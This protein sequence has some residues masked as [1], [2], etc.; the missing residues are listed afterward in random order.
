MVDG[1]LL[2]NPPFQGGVCG[3]L[4]P[5]KEV[6]RSSKPRICEG[7]RGDAAREVTASISSRVA[8]DSAVRSFWDEEGGST[9]VESGGEGEE[10]AV[11][12]NGGDSEGRSGMVEASTCHNE[13]QKDVSADPNDHLTKADAA[14]EDAPN[15]TSDEEAQEEDPALALPDALAVGAY[16]T[17]A[18][19]T[20]P[21]I[22]KHG[23]FAKIVAIHRNDFIDHTSRADAHACRARAKIGDGYGDHDDSVDV[24]YVLGGREKRVAARYVEVSGDLEVAPP[25]R[26]TLGRCAR[27]HCK[28]L[29]IDCGHSQDPDSWAPCLRPGCGEAAWDCGH[30]QDPSTWLVCARPGCNGLAVS[31]LH[32]QDPTSW[33]PCGFPGCGRPL[34]EGCLHPQDPEVWAAATAASIAR[35]A[36]REAA[37]AAKRGAAQS[38]PAW[39]KA[40]NREAAAAAAGEPKAKERRARKRPRQ[41]LTGMH[42]SSS[43]TTATKDEK[44]SSA[45]ESSSEDS[46]DGIIGRDARRQAQLERRQARQKRRQR[47]LESSGSEDG[48]T[49]TDDEIQVL[50]VHGSL[51]QEPLLAVA[52]APAAC[53]TAL[54]K[55]GAEKAALQGYISSSDVSEP[56]DDPSV[57]EGCS[58]RESGADLVDQGSALSATTADGFLVGEGDRAARALPADVEASLG[59]VAAARL[60]RWRALPTAGARRAKVLS[61]CA[62]L[63]QRGLP[64]FSS[65][66]AETEARAKTVGASAEPAA[67]SFA[68]GSGQGVDGDNGPTLG[69]T[70]A[71]RMEICKLREVVLGLRAYATKRLRRGCLDLA[72]DVFRSNL[73]SFCCWKDLSYTQTHTSRVSPGD[74]TREVAFLRACSS[75]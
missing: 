60:A 36:S 40:A 45:K 8:P 70:A 21:G 66:V 5:R 34:D 46:L 6:A 49:F 11:T 14:A 58:G 63:E 10:G 67:Y 56:E 50:R 20:W 71:R 62:Y 13:A 72:D 51:Q 9:E 48:E 75:L 57:V 35:K 15:S 30:S 28:S 37:K 2:K 54:E 44:T 18:A 74:S 52:A 68:S 4:L 55:Q 22:N 26:Q 61:A 41:E 69:D 65:R 31:C 73:T 17:I 12:P 25:K 33:A 43:L 39:L 1:G 53:S 59:R 38:A 23:G 19:R 7:S 47:W 16:V 42:A 3:T 27:P 32:T 64:Y 24:A 29:V